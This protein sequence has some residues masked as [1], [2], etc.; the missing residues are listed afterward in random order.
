MIAPM[1]KRTTAF[2]LLTSSV[3][4]LTACSSQPAKET[5]KPGAAAAQPAAEAKGFTEYPIGDEQEAEGLNVALVYF[6]PVPMVPESKAGLTPAQADMHLEADISA[7]EKNPLGFGIGEF[8]PY[9]KVSYT[10]K[11]VSSGAVAEGSFMPMN[12]A[13]GGHYGANVKMPGGAGKYKIT[14]KI[15]APDEYLLHTDSET[16][17]NG[18][19]WSTPVELNWDFDFVPRK[20]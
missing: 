2:A 11:N 4:I 16:G 15:K 13:D 7:G 18:R 9:L 10:I 1:L 12:A 6:Q 5:A 17:V 3:L 19:W 8:V 20:W 14:V